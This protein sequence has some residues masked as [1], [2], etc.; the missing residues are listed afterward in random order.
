MLSVK[1]GGI[2]YHFLSLLYDLTWDWS[3]VSQTIGE[4]FTHLANCPVKMLEGG[5]W[6]SIVLRYLNGL[7][8]YYV[9]IKN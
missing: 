3:L 7:N 5:D 4:P 2:K 6:G 8:I 1:Q 9:Q